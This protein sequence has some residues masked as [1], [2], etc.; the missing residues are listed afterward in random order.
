MNVDDPDA[1]KLT[2]Y[3]YNAMLLEPPEHVEPAKDADLTHQQ[4]LNEITSQLDEGLITFDEAF[5]QLK[6]IG[7]LF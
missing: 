3:Q 6:Q 2:H 5:E 4:T 7:V 1:Q